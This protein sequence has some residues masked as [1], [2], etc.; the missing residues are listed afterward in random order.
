MFVIALDTAE[1][2]RE[3]RIGDCIVLDREVRW[4]PEPSSLLRSGVN[5]AFS[6]SCKDHN[7]Q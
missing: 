5:G 6:E 4:W 2:S 7:D 1:H 3:G